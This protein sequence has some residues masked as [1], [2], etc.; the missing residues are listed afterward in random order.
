LEPRPWLG[1]PAEKQSCKFA[2]FFPGE[3]FLIDLVAVTLLFL[4]PLF[5]RG[6]FMDMMCPAGARG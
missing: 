2:A 4:M 1:R 6:A 5:H 3:I